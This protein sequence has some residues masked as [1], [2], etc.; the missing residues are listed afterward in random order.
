[1]QYKIEN[2]RLIPAPLNF[3]TPDGGTIFN[4]PL[5]VEAMNRYGYTVTEAEAEEWRKE[6]P[7]IPPA[8]TTCTKYELVTCLRTYFP[9]L[10]ANLRD[11]YMQNTD[12]Q[13]WWNSV[14]D[15]DR[16]NADFQQTVSALGITSEQLDAIFAKIGEA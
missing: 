9:E 3:V 16:D 14:L 4:F 5:N 1:M 10:L 15:L 7:V 11:A 12:L 2:N 6:H 13:F 8:R